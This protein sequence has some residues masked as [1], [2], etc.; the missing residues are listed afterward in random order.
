MRPVAFADQVGRFRGDVAVL[1]GRGVGADDVLAIAVSGGPDSM[2][3][4]ALAHAAW[5]RQVIAATVD[6]GLRAAGA[7]EAAMVAGFCATLTI[8]PAEAGAQSRHIGNN[9][10]HP[11]ST[12][13]PTGPRPLPGW[14]GDGV[15]HTTLRPIEP[16]GTA[17]LQAAARAARY[18]LLA[19]WAIAGG[20][21]MLATAHH[22]DDQAET[23]LMRAARGSGLAGLSGIRPK[24]DISGR[25]S[26]AGYPQGGIVAV[27]DEWT[28]PLIRPL[29]GWRCSELRDIVTA[30]GIPFVDDP[31]N[32][33]DH[34]DRTRFRRLLAENESLDP[35]RLAASANFTR[36]G[37]E[38]LE[39]M[40][41][42]FW[43]NRKIARPDVENCD[44]QAWLDLAGLPRDIKRRLSRTAIDWIRTVNGIT[45]PAF[46]P[47]TNIEPL[48]DAIEAGT[49][50]THAGILVSRTGDIWH[51]C[52]APPRRDTPLSQS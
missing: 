8:T 11:P 15:P 43:D 52:K 10:Q 26:H 39:A 49:S 44:D 41:D 29:L 38:T 7:D 17:N 40:T 2:A 51:F 34:Y 22:A 50:A 18:A 28:I 19:D 48:L 5:P 30:N 13:F 16:L 42:W 4:L 24:R 45:R 46:S 9:A 33:D 37:H 3:L 32:A 27:Y 23:F 12:T 21:T 6:H 20:A 14:R 1:L 47:A 35:V 31:S 36:E 25:R